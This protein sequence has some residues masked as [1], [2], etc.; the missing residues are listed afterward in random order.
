M[1]EINLSPTISLQELFTRWPATMP[2]FFK[3]HMICVG[4][5]M[6]AF[7]TLEDAVQNY[8]LNWNLFL[9]DLQASIQADPTSEP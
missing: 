5:S 3:R 1:N 7:D 2:V 4:C 8:G 6:A 9:D